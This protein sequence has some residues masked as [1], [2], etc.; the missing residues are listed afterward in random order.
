MGTIS[1]E[2]M[3]SFSDTVSDMYTLF[4]RRY[5]FMKPF[6]M[7]IFLFSS[8]NFGI[9]IKE[10][11]IVSGR[12]SVFR[13]TDGN[14]VKEGIEDEIT[15][16]ITLNRKH[17]DD[18]MQNRKKYMEKPYKLLK[19]FPAFL[20]SV[21]I[22]NRIIKVTSLSGSKVTLRPGVE[23]DFHILYKWYNDTELNKLAGWNNSRVTSD[24]LR[25]NM[26]RSFGYDPMNLMIDNKEGTPIGTIQ[27][28]DFN[29]QDKSCK[30]GIRIGDRDYWGKGY[31]EDAVKTI[32]EYAFMKIDIYRVTLKVYEY[33]ERAVKCYLKCGFRNEGRTRQS[34]YIDGKFYDEIIM[35]ALKSEYIELM[36]SGK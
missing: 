26:S 20:K 16:K 5:P 15:V 11:G 13:S 2:N 36:E 6:L 9:I 27:L 21:S 10:E 34:A 19:F 18:M 12:F 7:N 14:I 8:G 25:Y 30:L 24:K 29:E 32:L 22:D 23:S 1:A 28:Y 4:F 3:K 31:G 35:G 17:Y 33:N